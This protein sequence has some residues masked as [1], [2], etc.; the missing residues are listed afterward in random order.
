MSANGNAVGTPFQQITVL[1]GVTMNAPLTTGITLLNGGVGPTF[2]RSTA[3]TVNDFEGVVHTA[4]I[5]ESRFSGARRVENLLEF[6]EDFSNDVWTKDGTA[7][8]TGTNVLN[9][10]AEED[11]VRQSYT[12]TIN[13]GDTYAGEVCLSGTN[14]QTCTVQL[15]RNGVGTNESSSEIITLT[16]TPTCYKISHTFLNIQTGLRLQIY[17]NI[18]QTATQVIATDAQIE[19]VTGSQTEASEYV[20]TGVSVQTCCTLLDDDFST[21]TTGDYTEVTSTLSW[22]DTSYL[23]ATYTGTMVGGVAVADIL[24]IGK[25]Y[26]VKFKAKGTR[27]TI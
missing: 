15:I 18:G 24:T 22:E 2:S 12:N 17:R 21:D 20:S 7:T 16:P 1:G 3:A 10:P 26:H 4:K 14:G 13:V 11:R 9:F 27:L 23:R 19:L 5:N 6:S 8:I 25:N